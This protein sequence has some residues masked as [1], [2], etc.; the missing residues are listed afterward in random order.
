MVGMKKR[1]Y[2]I[3]T[4]NL[5]WWIIALLALAG[6]IVLAFVLKGKGEGAID[7]FKNII[8]IR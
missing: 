5:V 2:S 8:K 4:D 3:V 1:G 6:F 7:F